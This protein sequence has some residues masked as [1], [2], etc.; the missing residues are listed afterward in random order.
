MNTPDSRNPTPPAGG[1]HAAAADAARGTHQRPWPTVSVVS[2]NFRQPEVTC[3]MLD[4]LRACTYPALEVVLVDNGSL[5]DDSARWR[6]H[7]PGVVHV[8]SEDNLG[9]A[10]GTNL[11]IAHATG[12]LI[13]LL[14][15]DTLVEPGFLGP[16][17]ATMHAHGRVGIVS[18]K[19][20]F[21]EPA[22]TIQYAGAVITQPALGRGIKI[23]HGERDTGRYDDVRLTELPHGACMLVRREVFARVGLLPEFYFMYFEEHDFAVQARRAG[24]EVMYCGRSAIVH[25]QGR[26]LDAGSPRK[27]YYL[28]RNRLTFYRRTLSR[29]A[30]AGFLLYYL[31]VGLPVHVLRLARARRLD[32]LRAL[33]EA[34]AWHARR[35]ALASLLP[36][37]R[38][39]DRRPLHLPHLDTAHP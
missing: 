35:S 26:S 38:I 20:C 29:G 33:A 32:H 15:N 25:R 27:T 2:V 11:G 18:P 37:A 12:D 34:L 36:G 13:L 24:Y 39:V 19:I 17:V 3:D 1:H 23:G 6:Y 10:G 14:N 8:R 7:F 21:A 31:L 28:H 5:G 22:R 4:S 16:L 9:F 30:Y